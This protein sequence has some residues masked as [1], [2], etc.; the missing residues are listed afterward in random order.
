MNSITSL[1]YASSFSS[2]FAHTFYCFTRHGTT[3][4]TNK[5]SKFPQNSFSTKRRRS[6]NS[7]RIRP[8]ADAPA[9]VKRFSLLSIDSNTDDYQSLKLV[10]DVNQITYLT[11]S[12]F[13]HFISLAKD[14]YYDLKTL[15]SLDYNNR[16]VFSC[17]KSTIQFTAGVLLGGF[18]LISVIR[19]LINLG[20]AFRSWL[21]KLRSNTDSKNVV[22][23][24]DRSLG[25][26]E[27]VVARRVEEEERP[28][29][30]KRKMFGVLDSPFE[31]PGWVFGSGLERDDWRSYRIRSASKL[32]KW[33][34]VS[35]AEKQE[36]LAVDKQEYQR[37]ANRLIRG[38]C[39]YFYFFFR[40]F[41]Y[42]YASS[43]SC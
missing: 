36:L 2:S 3:A 42:L 43:F 31:K 1:P 21:F 37:D 32:P 34:P 38:W 22:V 27:V 14:A 12:R 10:L 4:T 13:S 25:G 33:W 23:R 16:I 29:E 28:K 6:R 39:V 30:V 11:S 9:D 40:L 26:K 5:L 17:R 8:T 15:I 7:R 18:V 20:L 35:V 41:I 19:V 24:R